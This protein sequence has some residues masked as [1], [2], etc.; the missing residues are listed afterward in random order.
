MDQDNGRTEENRIPRAG[1]ASDGPPPS[2]LRLTIGRGCPSRR[3][4]RR[5]RA[6]ELQTRRPLADRQGRPLRLR[7]SRPV[8]AA[9]ITIAD[10]GHGPIAFGT[11]QAGLDIE[12]SRSSGRL[13]LDEMDE[14]SGNGS[15]ELLDD[16][17]IEFEF[18]YHSGEEAVLKAQREFFNTL[19]GALSPK[20]TPDT[21]ELARL[22][23]SHCAAAGRPAFAVRCAS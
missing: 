8:W 19:R 18:A 17:S 22:G 6:G 2:R 9:T 23:E 4:S 5:E 3:Q 7:S 11:F 13:H 21:E 16:S 15:A 14:V 12:S 20:K 1:S 10:H